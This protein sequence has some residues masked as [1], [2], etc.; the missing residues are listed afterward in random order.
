MTDY[1]E[2][3]LKYKQKYLDLKQSESLEQSGGGKIFDLSKNYPEYK[4]GDLHKNLSNFIK[5][6]GLNFKLKYEEHTLDIQIK[7]IKLPS[8]I[9][10]FSMVYDIPA[11]TYKLKPFVIDFIDP[12]T[13]E[14]NNNTYIRNIHKTDKISGTNMVKICLA[15]NKILGADKTCLGDGTSII[16]EQNKEQLDLSYLKLIEKGITFY[17]NL[18]FDYEFTEKMEDI[19]FGVRYLD[20]SKF[21]NDLHKN[22]ENIRN[23]KTNDLIKECKN[24]LTLVNEIIIDNYKKKFEIL[25]DNSIPVVVD[26]IHQENPKNKINDLFN[27]CKTVLDILNK[28]SNET[29]FYKL[30]IKLFK[31]SCAEYS[32]LLNFVSKNN[33]T[34]IIYGN[35]KITRDYIKYFR[36]L[37][38]Y[39]HRFA[40]FY[41][42]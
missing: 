7:K 9:E 34:K 27:E 11:R 12:R 13:L 33:R 5:K 28:Y 26:T 14:K 15:I 22:L 39:R 18:G 23:I 19:Y 30:L 36:Y 38:V 8:Q 10:Y 35:K 21:L 41:K 1:Y 32:T 40:F 3:Y 16:C 25:I 37:S 24:T 17:M 4:K 29:Y 2:K 42:F 20:K 31:D 6:H